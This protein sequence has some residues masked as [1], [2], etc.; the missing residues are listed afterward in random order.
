[1]TDKKGSEV[2]IGV[3]CCFGIILVVLFFGGFLGSSVA[4]PYC[5]S[6]NVQKVSSYYDK[7]TDTE[8][9]DYYCNNCHSPFTRAF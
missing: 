7:A 5:G 3:A 1:M 4:C 2:C 6:H 8:I 9:D